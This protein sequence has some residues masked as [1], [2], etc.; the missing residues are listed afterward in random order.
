MEWNNVADSLSALD[1]R[2]KT[3]SY[4]YCHYKLIYYM[5]RIH[6]PDKNFDIKSSRITPSLILF[7]YKKRQFLSKFLSHG[8]KHM[9]RLT[10]P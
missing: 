5:L 4:L 9:N 6:S 1:V 10:S 3:S 2:F 8:G 7:H